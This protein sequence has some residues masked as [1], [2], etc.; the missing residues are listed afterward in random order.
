MS[1]WIFKASPDQYRLDERLKDKEPKIQWRVTRYKDE[2]KTGD[3]V[4]L[5]RTGKDRGICA[6]MNVDSNPEDKNELESEQ[7]FYVERDTLVRTRV[8]GTLTHRIDCIS[9]LALKVTPGLENLSVFSGYQQ[10]TNFK[11]MPEEGKIIMRLVEAQP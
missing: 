6:V 5:W 11:V 4:F 1:Y 7:K 3:T 10:A 2:I 8:A 9:S